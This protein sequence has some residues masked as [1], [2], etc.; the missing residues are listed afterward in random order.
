MKAS[1]PFKNSIK[2]Y[3]DKRAAEDELFAVTYKKENKNLDEFTQ[4]LVKSFSLVSFVSCDIVLY[5]SA[6]IRFQC[7]L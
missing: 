1:N 6:K 4:F 3:L 5:C 2:A 7:K